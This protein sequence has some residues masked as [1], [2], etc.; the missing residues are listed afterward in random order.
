MLLERKQCFE[1][2]CK[3]THYFGNFQ[4]ILDFFC[5]FVPEK[6]IVMD[7]KKAEFTLSAPQESMCRKDTKTEYAFIGRWDVGKTSLSNM[8]TK[9][10]KL[11]KTSATPGKTLLINHFINNNEWDLVALQRY[12]F[13]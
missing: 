7:I 12:L 5:N 13:A 9:N 1:K 8:L 4:I 2:R 3:G 11:A 6:E 10:Q